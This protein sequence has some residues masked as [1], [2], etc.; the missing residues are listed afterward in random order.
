VQQDFAIKPHTFTVISK[1]F[2]GLTVL[3][4]KTAN[5]S[6][7]L[8]AQNEGSRF[9]R[10]DSNIAADCMESHSRKLQS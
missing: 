6:E 2:E 10:N 5:V 9:L 7:E 1:R 3:N 4:V 8:P